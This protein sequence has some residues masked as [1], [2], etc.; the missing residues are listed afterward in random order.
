MRGPSRTRRVLSTLTVALLG[1][2]PALALAQD[3]AVESPTA[4]RLRVTTASEEAGRQFWT[5][6][7][8]AR[9]I[10]FGRATTHF[11]RAIALDGNLGLA[12][13]VRAAIAPGLT[14]EQRQAEVERGLATMTSASTGELL[15]ALAFREFVAGNMRQAQALFKTASKILPGD[16]NLAF[17]AAQLTTGP[18]GPARGVDAL[19]AAIEKFPDDAPSYNTLAYLLWQT[20]DQDGA[21]RA[22]KRYV[23]LAPDH[24]NSHDSY[25]E[26]LQWDSRFSEALAHYGRAVQLD[27]SYVGAYMGMAEVLQLTARGEE[28]RK[29]IRQAI[30]R[31]PAPQTRVNY[32]R[33]LAHSFL[34][35]GMLKEAMEQ[36]AVA[37]REAQANDRKNLAA[38]THR[39]MAVADALLGQGST[40]ASHLAT[41][42]EI[43]GVDV[44]QQ[45][46]A[47]AVAHGT[48]GDIAAARQAAEKLATVAQS[49]SQYVTASRTANA[50]ILLRENKPKEALNQLSGAK[51]DDAL[52]RALLAEC[53]RATGNTA[54]G[55]TLRSQVIND[56]QF[57][58]IDAYATI[59]RV[60]AARIKT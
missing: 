29:Q 46:I 6:L 23:E 35:D 17:Y 15:T 30:T 5:G 32:T 49:D 2:A 18:E 8:D 39:E 7:G 40:I 33:A 38:Q 24:P 10:F 44:P 1:L 26:L 56:P 3:V 9:N 12:R 59:A 14:T 31:A 4:L 45:L 57:D 21:F 43:G 22:V 52:V 58:L 27:S 48:A 20:G 19:R 50:I 53:Y 25:A 36:L 13:V 54:D 55:R 11:D 28:A 16:P 37:A 60:R 34:M 47:T 51:A 42:A 41:A